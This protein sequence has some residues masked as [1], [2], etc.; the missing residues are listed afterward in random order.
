VNARDWC[1][2]GPGQHGRARTWPALLPFFGLAYTL[3][4][5]LWALPAL[6][7]LGWISQKP[8]AYWHL[9]GG[10]GPLLAAVVLT[11]ATGRKPALRDLFARAVRWNV[12]F[13]WLALAALGP[14]ALFLIAAG[15]LRAFAGSWPAFDRFG[16]STEY[17][18]LPLAVYWV[19]NIVCY[20]FGEEV[21]W[22]GF[23]LP[24]LQARYGALQASSILSL[25]WAAWHLPLFAF[26]DGL[27][28]MNVAEIA[29]WFASLW[30][31]SVLLT[32]LYNGAQESILVVALFHGTL[33]IAINSPAGDSIQTIMGALLTLCGLAAV[34][35]L[36]RSVPSRPCRGP[37]PR[38]TGSIPC[39]E[40]SSGEG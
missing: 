23:A 24:R 20:G 9:A 10:F 11:A 40:A 32:W 35:A 2:S 21:G 37:V 38:S 6:S 36:K 1:E 29:G 34:A 13:R 15:L 30:L 12:G 33:D 8:S 31:G 25:F 4:W 14:G 26:S 16:E 19:A 27:S 17:P 5:S 7:G 39:G 18:D 3:S 22:R 28:S